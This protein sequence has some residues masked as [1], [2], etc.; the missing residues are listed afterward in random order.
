MESVGERV[1][2]VVKNHLV[3]A[4]TLAILVA[5][6][7]GLASAQQVQPKR[8]ST[9]EVASVKAAPERD[10]GTYSR[11]T[12]MAPEIT[13]NPARIDFTDVT[14]DGV[15]C[16]AYGVRALDIKA[17]AWM[18]ERRYDIHAKVPADA[19]TGH[20]PE[21]LQNL[22]ADRF[23]MKL[24]WESHQESGYVLTV[25]NGGL[26][27][28]RSA[29]DT[30]R[31]VS[32]RSN[33]HF[34]LRRITMTEFANS[35]RGNLG[36]PVIDKTQLSDEYDIELDAAPDSMP[37]LPAFLRGQDASA[38]PTIFQALRGLGLELTRAAKAPVNYFVVDSALK[39]PIAN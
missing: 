34:D 8:T 14:L 29:P 26:K 36:Q 20:I 2:S 35:L 27:L 37:G 25:A 7:A 12:G 10:Y 17:P 6:V 23:Q 15:I 3:A 33:G 16:R 28:K 9:F 22:L 11:P 30:R 19:P 18:Q 38:L 13:G 39:V 31:T 24:H 1:E 32:L 5:A 4:V 21:M